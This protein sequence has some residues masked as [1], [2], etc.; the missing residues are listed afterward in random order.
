MK[1]LFLIA[2]IALLAIPTLTGCG[3]PAEDYDKVVSDLAAAQTQ[4]QKLETD[5]ASVQNEVSQLEDENTTLRSELENIT[6]EYEALQTEYNDLNATVEEVISK[7]E[8]AYMYE[9]VLVELLLPAITG[10]ELTAPFK[11]SNVQAFVDKTDDETLKEKFEAW[12]KS[13]SNRTLVGEFLAHALLTLE[14]ILYY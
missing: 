5:L 10:D 2:L 8:S 12:S 6:G 4:I 9:Q 14:D 13:P 11:I 3:V 1:K 7:L